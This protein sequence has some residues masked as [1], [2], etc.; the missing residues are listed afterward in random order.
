[1]FD[2]YVNRTKPIITDS[3]G[4]QVFSL[5]HG[6]VHDELNMKARSSQTKNGAWAP[7]VVKVTEEG[8]T[9]RSYIDG[10]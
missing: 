4:F 9:F 1:M 10:P 8:A 6:S 7:S 5:S 3:G 2:R